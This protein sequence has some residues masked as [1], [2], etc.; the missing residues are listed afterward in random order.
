MTQS[1]IVS[2]RGSGGSEWR[3]GGFDVEQ[4]RGEGMKL[5]MGGVSQERSEICR[6]KKDLRKIYI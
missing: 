2:E 1:R 5:L 6:S 4:Y 3:R